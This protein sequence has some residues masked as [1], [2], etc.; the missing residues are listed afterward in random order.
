MVEKEMFKYVPLYKP[1]QLI[2]GNEQ[3]AVVSGWVDK[4]AIGKKVESNQFAVIGQLYSS[5]SGINFLIRNL[6]YNPH[7]R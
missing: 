4:S 6:L 2:L 1:N 7:V 3:T 5:I